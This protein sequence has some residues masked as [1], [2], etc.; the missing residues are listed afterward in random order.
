[1]FHDINLAIQGWGADGND[2]DEF[3]DSPPVFADI[4]KD[5]NPEIIL[6]SDHERAGEYI[7]RGN[8]LWALN[9]DMTRFAGFEV[10]KTTGKPLYTGY[11]DNI[12]QV[13]PSPAI[14]AFGT[15]K[16]HIVEPSYDGNLH[17]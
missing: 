14:S 4:D 16:I 11:E 1:M 2:L 9:P 13:A 10:P 3:T 15:G 17:C 5:G 8:S 6:F 7:N 12:V